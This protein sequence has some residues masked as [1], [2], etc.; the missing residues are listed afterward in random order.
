MKLSRT[1]IIESCVSEDETR[2]VLTNPQLEITTDANGKRS[3]VIIATDGRCLASVPVEIEDGDQAGK[4][5]VAALELARKQCESEGECDECGHAIKGFIGPEIAIACGEVVTLQGGESFPR[6]VEGGKTFPDTSEVIA[7]VKPPIVTVS[8]SM[9]LLTRICKALGTEQ[10]VL[11]ISGD[12]DILKVRPR[13]DSG[14]NDGRFAL[15]MP[16]RPEKNF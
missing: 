9:N 12:K 8:V 1:A 6:N 2:L 11:E 14:Y 16:M 3:G 13:D 5:P 15:W 7:D 4:V 10:V